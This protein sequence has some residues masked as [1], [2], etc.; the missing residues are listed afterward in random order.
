MSDNSND[1]KPCCASCNTVI[2]EADPLPCGLCE[3]YFHITLPCAGFTRTSKNIITGG[4]AIFVCPSCRTALAGKTIRAYLL[5]TADNTQPKQDSIQQNDAH[6]SAQYHPPQNDIKQLTMQVQQ[7]TAIVAS[8]SAK[9]DRLVS[10]NTTNRSLIQP[11]EQRPPAPERGRDH[12][13]KPKIVGGPTRTGTNPIDLTGLS[14]ASIVAQAP[15]PKFWL[16][17]AGFNPRITNDDVGIIVS[18]CL[19]LPDSPKDIARLV[20]REKDVN[21]LSFVSF[22]IGLDPSLKQRA[23]DDVWPEGVFF[24]EF[25]NVPKNG[26]P[27]TDQNSSGPSSSSTA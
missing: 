27:Q 19:N 22:K 18:R 10:G 3:K 6:Q 9:V 24:R 17:L 13:V 4:K 2:S 12:R 7:L 15:P 26:P 14:T 20:A 11:E 21:T 16:Y 25:I 5:G 1:N 23:L 8:L